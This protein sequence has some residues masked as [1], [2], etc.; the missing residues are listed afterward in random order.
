MN[1][2]SCNSNVEAEIVLPILGNRKVIGELNTDSHIYPPFTNED[3]AF[4]KSITKSVS[5]IF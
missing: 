1:Y 2:L 4:L 5:E 3:E